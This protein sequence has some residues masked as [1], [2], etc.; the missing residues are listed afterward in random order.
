MVYSQML[1]R[2]VEIGDMLFTIKNAD[3]NAGVPLFITQDEIM[4]NMVAELR[5]N[6]VT[7]G[8]WQNTVKENQYNMYGAM[9]VDMNAYFRR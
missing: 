5:N 2:Q 3:Q 6:S 4:D 1:G 8:N 7:S 9:Q